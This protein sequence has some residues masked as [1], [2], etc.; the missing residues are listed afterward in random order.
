MRGRKLG[1]V[2]SFVSLGVLPLGAQEVRGRLDFADE[3]RMV[4]CD[5]AA[6]VPCFRIQLNIVDGQGKPL[7][8]ELPA[9]DK[10]A[11]SLTVKIGEQEITP[12]YATIPSDAT[13]ATRG[14]VALILIDISGSMNR[15][16]ATGQTRFDAAKSALEHYL[17]GFQDGLDEVA[18]VAFE[19]HGVVAGIKAAK[20]AS[21]KDEA[22]QQVNALPA[23]KPKN[24][25]GL[26]SAVDVGLDVL[27]ERLAGAGGGAGA[28][29]GLLVVMTDGA[30][31]VYKGDD[32]GL[33]AGD[34]GLAL[35]GGRVAASGLNVVG[36]GFG[37]VSQIDEK[38]LSRL[39][40]K[41]YMAS[42]LEGL[43]KIFTMARTVL[44]NRVRAM[45]A[46]P[47]PDRASLAGRDL[48][49]MARLKLPTGETLT[50]REKIWETPQIG[51]P[52]FAGKCEAP[53]LL[54]AIHVSPPSGGGWMALLRP[55]LVFAGLGVLILILWLW[56]PRLAWPEQYI[57]IAP[58]SARW[59]EQAQA[60]GGGAR[61]AGPA[62]PG[63][64]GTGPGGMRPPVR[65]PQEKTVLYPRTDV[66]G[67]TRTRLEVRPDKD[68][69]S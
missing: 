2:F 36:V 42:D 16:L 6:S 13:V 26:Y 43:K 20:F 8:L 9:P 7:G 50:S 55:V 19:S 41:Y 63:F 49:V 57:G 38:A 4:S 58:S 39:S 56:V 37:D 25:T 47:W 17:T 28:P 30:N 60:G 45:F 54:A 61:A 21:T 23:P 24:N 34:D 5:P 1:L 32:P 67:M 53:E 64:A 66:T 33:L 10:L 35:V 11:S 15:V 59:A 18:I 46:S 22:L 3:I 48:H 65:A 44:R 40:T 62:P 27:K 68:A 52:L 31:E 12:F 69:K 51:V 29:E 14:R